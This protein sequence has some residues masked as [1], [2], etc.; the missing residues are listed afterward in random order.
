MAKAGDVDQHRTVDQQMQ[1]G[2]HRAEVSADI[3][4]VGDHK[5]ADQRIKQGRRMMAP[6]VAGET[7]AGDPA[8]MCADQLDR[9]HQRIGE[10]QRPPQAVAE[11]RAC[12]GISG[13]AAGI[14]VRSAGD[15]AGAHNI[16]QLRPFRLLDHVLR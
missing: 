15:Q 9:A 6:H 11:L 1:G 10:Q 16:A 13:D 8:N 2:G 3:D 7:P 5:Q 4:G 12:L 14:V